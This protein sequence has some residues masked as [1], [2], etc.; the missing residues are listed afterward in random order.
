MRKDKVR[1]VIDALPEDVDLDALLEKLYL[2]K[3]IE[4]AEEQLAQGHGVSHDDAK[5]RLGRWLE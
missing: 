1:Q 5:R 3:K 4:I 2:L